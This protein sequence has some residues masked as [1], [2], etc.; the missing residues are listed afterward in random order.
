MFNSFSTMGCASSLSAYHESGISFFDKLKS[1]L[2]IVLHSFF[3]CSSVGHF[4]KNFG[5]NATHAS[6]MASFSSR[7]SGMMALIF[8]IG[9]IVLSK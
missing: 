3:T 7:D 6:I 5:A 1:K 8:P 4:S 2:V 9:V